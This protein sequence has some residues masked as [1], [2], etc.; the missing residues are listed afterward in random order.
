LIK[1]G[2]VLSLDPDLGDMASTDVL[3]DGDKIAAVGQNLEVSPRANVIDAR[4]H[5]VM[6][7]FVDTHRH[8]W[9][10]PVRGVLPSC[11][12]DQYFAGMLDNI[13]VQYRAED[14]Y[15]A[16]LMG[17]LEAI[18]AGITT[19]LDWSHVNNTPEH[20]DAA[21]HGLAE[22]GIRAVYAHGVPV[23]ADWW[24]YSSKDHP[25]DIRRIR[26]EYFSSD[27]QLLTLALAARAPDA[28]SIALQPVAAMSGRRRR[29]TRRASIS[30]SRPVTATRT[31]TPAPVFR[32]RRCLPTTRLSSHS[33]STVRRSGSG[34]R[35]KSTTSTWPSVPCRRCSRSTSAVGRAKWS[36]SATRT[37]PTT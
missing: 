10:T 16:N 27:D 4:H 2:Y 37:A 9:Q 24:A 8:T 13:G 6:P 21:V 14:V 23:G 3:I 1:G 11:T 30:I 20:A 15:I 25:E 31:T 35:V 12:L 19:L 5:I 33:T 22:A 26:K 29:R 7:G 17:A 18:N 28:P 32:R 34:D 36:A